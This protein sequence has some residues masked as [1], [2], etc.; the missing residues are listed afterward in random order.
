M[1]RRLPR[2]SIQK[3]KRMGILAL[4]LGLVILMTTVERGMR[5]MIQ[6]VAES[7]ANSVATQIINQAVADQLTQMN[8]DY[9]DM[10]ELDRDEQGNISSVRTK[11]AAVNRFQAEISLAV[12]AAIDTYESQ[13]INIPFGT[14]TG[15]ELLDG[16][17][18][19]VPLTISMTGSM[20]ATITSNFESAGINQ[21]RHQIMLTIS[22]EARAVV[23]WYGINAESRDRLYRGRNCFG[24]QCPRRLYPCHQRRR[25]GGRRHFS[26]W[27][28][29]IRHRRH[30]ITKRYRLS[31]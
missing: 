16:I 22:A 13:K 3:R 31:N 27:K 6:S 15:L 5:P 30:S 9:Q 14:F 26:I 1:R 20:K 18:P 25:L 2:T 24:W 4:L 7:R 12:Q 19:G 17:G 11:M 21:T 10:V 28:E 23:P 29:R 8:L